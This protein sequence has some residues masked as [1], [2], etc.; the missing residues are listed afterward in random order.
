MS[1][2]LGEETASYSAI[3]G[4]QAPPRASVPASSGRAL[5]HLQGSQGLF[6]S[7]MRAW[8]G[9]FWFTS[10]SNK[11]AHQSVENGLFLIYM[12]CAFQFYISW[13]KQTFFF[14]TIFKGERL[15]RK[16]TL[17]VKL[18]MDTIEQDYEILGMDELSNF[19]CVL[20]M[21]LLV[22]RGPRNW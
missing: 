8:E 12:E 6:T 18:P 2:L 16:K 17:M 1:C 15:N 10:G 20:K 4:S 21:A 5:T 19:S 22:V 14:Q 9:V 7:A 3:D 13:K 11:Q